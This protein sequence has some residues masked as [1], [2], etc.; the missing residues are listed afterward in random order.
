[1]FIKDDQKLYKVHLKLSIKNN[2]KT[3]SVAMIYTL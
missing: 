2:C 3:I 1:M